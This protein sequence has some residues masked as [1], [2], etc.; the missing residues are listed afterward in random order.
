MAEPHAP[1]N[2]KERSKTASSVEVIWDQI[3]SYLRGGDLQF[4][5]IIT[6]LPSNETVKEYA[7]T[8]NI[9]IYNITDLR[10][11]QNYSISVFGATTDHEGAK[12][13][14]SVLTAEARK[15]LLYRR[16]KFA[17]CFSFIFESIIIY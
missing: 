9:T 1:A 14:L 17:N 10:A 5:K 16:K 6:R 13:K 7:V 2:L 12:A 15:F 11:F 8:S 3:P 4:Y